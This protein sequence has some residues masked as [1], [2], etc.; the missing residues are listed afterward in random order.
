MLYEE[1]DTQVSNRL[2][3]G[4]AT[5]NVR[6][7]IIINDN[8]KQNTNQI[9]NENENEQSNDLGIVITNAT[10]KWTDAQTE[11]SLESINLTVVPGRLVAII[12]PVGA[13]KVSNSKAMVYNYS[14]TKNYNY[15]SMISE[16]T[17]T[18]NFK[19]ITTFRR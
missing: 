13:G 8:I 4:K 6:K 14:N 7:P 16:F 18:S 11:N 3:T 1:K 15:I 19:R 2:K 9:Q 10:A 17:S 12:G 5:N